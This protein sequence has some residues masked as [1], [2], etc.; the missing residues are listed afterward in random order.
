MK[1]LF[2]L[3]IFGLVLATGPGAWADGDQ[4]AARAALQRGEIVSLER[5]L[6]AVRRDFSG[7]VVEVELEQ[8][9]GGWIYEVKLLAHHGAV[10]EARY[11][12]RTAALIRARG[13]GM[14]RDHGDRMGPMHRGN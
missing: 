12:A 2:S 6:D 8:E 7:R 14:E 13:R 3:L 9:D 4:D 11:D 1:R 10:I 5:I